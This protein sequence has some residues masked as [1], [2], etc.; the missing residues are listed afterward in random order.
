MESLKYD[1]FTATLYKY[2]SFLYIM[3]SES[4][5]NLMV[6]VSSPYAVAESRH[7][8]RCVYLAQKN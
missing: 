8:I 1:C 6:S 3:S 7:R 4:Q 2:P 5:G